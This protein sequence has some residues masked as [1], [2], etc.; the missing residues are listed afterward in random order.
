MLRQK[1]NDTLGRVR[2]ANGTF[3]IS[4]LQNAELMFGAGKEKVNSRV[5][6]SLGR[7][8]I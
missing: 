6:W 7:L 4:M 1:N 5:I 3:A 8:R 2:V